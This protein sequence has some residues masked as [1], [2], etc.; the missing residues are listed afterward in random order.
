LIN[1]LS[2]QLLRRFGPLGAAVSGAFLFIVGLANSMILWGIIKKLRQVNPFKFTFPKQLMPTTHFLLEDGLRC[3][4]S[5]AKLVLGLEKRLA[6]IPN[7]D[8]KYALTLYP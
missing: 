7:I 4:V 6:T 3:N 1:I 8:G 2:S 5:T